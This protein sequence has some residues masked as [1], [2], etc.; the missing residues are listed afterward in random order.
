MG[1]MI[2]RGK[3]M[4][5]INPKKPNEIEYSRNDGRTWSTRSS[6]SAYGDFTDLTENGKEILGTTSKGLY[7]SNNDGRTWSKRN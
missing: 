3:E 6:S 5:R 4:I 1:Q 7:Y 2:N